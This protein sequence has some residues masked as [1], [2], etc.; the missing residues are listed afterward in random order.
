MTDTVTPSN[1]KLHAILFALAAI[2]IIG[3]VYGVETL[4]AQHDAATNAKWQTILAT[5]TAQTVALQKQLTQDEATWAQIQAQLLAQNAKLANAVLTRDS[6]TQRKVTQDATLDAAGAASNINSHVQ[7]GSAVAQSNNVVLPLDTARG[8]AASLD[9]LP[10]V[11]ADL[12]DT[13][14]QLA[15]EVKLVAGDAADIDE[16][17]KLVLAQQQTL[18]DAQKKAASD[19]SVCRA[20]ARKGKLK[21][22]GIGYVAGFVS[23]VTAHLW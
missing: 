21:W 14:T 12:A 20:K 19:L 15:N 4:V 3:G 10:T 8:V 6:Q 23:G 7:N 5:Q 17:K 16:Q 18:V 22:F 2:S 1:W 11:Q 13:K 9:L